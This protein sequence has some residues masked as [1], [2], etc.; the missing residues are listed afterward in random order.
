MKRLIFLFT[1]LVFIG[2]S[3]FAQILEDEN[4]VFYADNSTPYNGTY[5]EYYLNGQTRLSID[6]KEGIKD[7][8]MY[9]YYEDGN[10]NEVR[11]YKNNKMHGTWITYAPNNVKI[12]EA[13]YNNGKKDGQWFIWDEKGT[14]RCEMFYKNGQKTGIWKMYDENGNLTD[15][16]DFTK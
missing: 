14:L 11:S 7:G 1:A 10:I 15:T 3:G 12:A 6:I 9:L 13:T 16:K 8:E 2:F 4:G 5:K